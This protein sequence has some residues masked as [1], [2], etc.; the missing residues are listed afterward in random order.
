M[1]NRQ[2]WGFGIIL[3]TSSLKPPTEKQLLAWKHSVIIQHKNLNMQGW[4]KHMHACF[5][6]EG[7]MHGVYP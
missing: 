1:F 2:W 5:S 3:G 6:K 4:P 7:Q